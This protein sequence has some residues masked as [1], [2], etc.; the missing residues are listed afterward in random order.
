MLLDV[1]QHVSTTMFAEEVEG[2]K[3]DQH[4]AQRWVLQGSFM[5]VT[6]HPGGEDVKL[7]GSNSLGRIMS[8]RGHF[9]DIPIRKHTDIKYMSIIIILVIAVAVII[10]LVISVHFFR[11]DDGDGSGGEVLAAEPPPPSMLRGETVHI[12]S[13]ASRGQDRQDRQDVERP[14]VPLR[15]ASHPF[16]REHVNRRLP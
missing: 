2:M 6:P 4:H 12:N 3:L 7:R 8:C 14:L 10:A 1:V 5:D 16:R 9:S 11:K 15:R 13:A